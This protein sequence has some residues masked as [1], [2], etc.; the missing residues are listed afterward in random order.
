MGSEVHL[1]VKNYGNLMSLDGCWW[2]LMWRCIINAIPAGGQW[3]WIALKP[4]QNWI[5]CAEAKLTNCYICEMLT[6][7]RWMEHRTSNMQKC[8]LNIFIWVEQCVRVF[9]GNNSKFFPLLI[10]ENWGIMFPKNEI[11]LPFFIIKNISSESFCEILI[12]PWTI[13]KLSISR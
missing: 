2:G 3:S 4:K 7:D 10:R 6:E 9:S 12:W 8:V 5:L 13:V 1:G 11:N